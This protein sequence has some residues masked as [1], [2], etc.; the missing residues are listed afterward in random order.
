MRS[1]KE[2]RPTTNAVL[3]HEVERSNQGPR[4]QCRQRVKQASWPWHRCHG[5]W[6]RAWLFGLAA[7]RL[8]FLGNR[9]DVRT[10]VGR[11]GKCIH[12]SVRTCGAKNR[13]TVQCECALARAGVWARSDGRGR[14]EASCCACTC[15]SAQACTCVFVH[16]SRLVSVGAL[17]FGPL[18][19]CR[20]S[21]CREASCNCSTESQAYRWMRHCTPYYI[22]FNAAPHAA[23]RCNPQ[24]YR[25]DT[26]HGALLFVDVSGYSKLADRW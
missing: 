1:H 6:R 25:R 24:E 8:R 11:T 9:R 2:E 15:L 14:S 10:I 12:I 13:Q 20:A 22:Y 21:S 26:F 5:A 19:L 18:I 23:T 7:C 16:G 4:P 3:G 17:I